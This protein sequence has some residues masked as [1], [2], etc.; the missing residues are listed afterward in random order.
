[1]LSQ[2]MTF[3]YR[4]FGP[5]SESFIETRNE[6]QTKQ[7]F[8]QTEFEKYNFDSS[9]SGSLQEASS[10]LDVLSNAFDQSAPN[11]ALWNYSLDFVHSMDKV[12]NLYKQRV[13]ELLVDLEWLILFAFGVNIL[14]I[15]LEFVFVIFPVLEKNRIYR[16]DQEA[17]MN[18]LSELVSKLGKVHLQVAHDVK[19]PVQAALMKCE[20]LEMAVKKNTKL[21]IETIDELRFLIDTISDNVAQIDRHIASK[22]LKKQHVKMSTVLSKVALT[23]EM[24]YQRSNATVILETDNK[25]FVDEIEFAIIIQNLISNSIKYSKPDVPPRI[26]IAMHSK[27]NWDIITVHDNGIGISQEGLVKI[28]DFSHR[29]SKQSA[30]DGKGIGLYTVKELVEAHGGTITAS[31]VLGSSTTFNIHLPKRETLESIVLN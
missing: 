5:E 27:A 19:S 12:N 16:L 3:A 21:Q 18:K 7:A 11:N 13:N 22:A 31:S 9:Y 26:I 10:K 15:I 17:K 29:E 28:F 1:M 2:R 30:V 8:L 25:L 24:A 4:E 6:L 14:A 23:L 20:M